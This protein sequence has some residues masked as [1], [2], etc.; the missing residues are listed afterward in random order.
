M[1]KDIGRKDLPQGRLLF[2]VVTVFRV[3]VF[4]ACLSSSSLA[5]GA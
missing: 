4:E 5:G 1:A 2:F 3:R